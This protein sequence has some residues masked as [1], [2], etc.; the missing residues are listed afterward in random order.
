MHHHL[1]SSS[2]WYAVNTLGG[3]EP[4]AEI[5][6]NRQGYVTYVPWRFTSVR[7]GKRFHQRRVSFFP[8]YLFV[9]FDAQRQRWRSIN[10]TM[11]VRRLIMAGNDPVPVPRGLVEAMIARTGSDD[12]LSFDSNLLPGQEIEVLTG[13]FANLIG[14]LDKIDERGRIKVLIEC[15]NGTVPVSLLATDV[16]AV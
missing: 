3:K 2:R 7:H 9:H 4:I 10:G 15:M 8:N 13:P 6:L 1:R 11:G 12:F 16:M 5:N 14:Q